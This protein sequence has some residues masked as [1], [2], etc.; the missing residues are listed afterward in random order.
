LI[1]ALFVEKGGAYYGLDGVDPWSRER[2]AR[3]YPG[4]DP[5]VAHPPCHLWVNFAAL[6][7][8]RYGGE[9][10]RPGNDGGMFA[11]ALAAVR[12]YGGVLEHPAS[13]NAWPAHQLPPPLRERFYRGW[14]RIQGRDEYMCEVWQSAYGHKAR[15]RTWL[16]YVGDPP[17]ELLWQRVPGSHQVGWFDRI[18]PTLSKAEASATPAAFRDTLLTL[19]AWAKRGGAP[20]IEMVRARGVPVDDEWGRRNRSISRR[21][22]TRARARMHG[23]LREQGAGW[24]RGASARRARAWSKRADRRNAG[25]ACAADCS[26]RA[27]VG[28]AEGRGGPGRR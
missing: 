4:P 1:A 21:R 24:Y 23:L 16:F 3:L 14:G 13:S 17:P 2:D 12:R 11:A 10:N 7:F 20:R 25:R 22:L 28:C 26:A 15:K 18:K 6:N 9:H 5:V 8:K 19:A 27:R